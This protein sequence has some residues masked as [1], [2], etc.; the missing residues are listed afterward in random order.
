MSTYPHPFTTVEIDP[1]DGTTP[2]DIAALLEADP[3]G[4]I[5]GGSE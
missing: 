4:R 3:W 5:T 2:A 1:A